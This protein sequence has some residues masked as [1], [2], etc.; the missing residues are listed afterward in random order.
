MDR[1]HAA[2]GRVDVRPALIDQALAVAEPSAGRWFPAAR[3]GLDDKLVLQTARDVV[4][5]GTEALSRT[6]VDQDLITEVGTR[7]HCIVDDTHRRRA[8]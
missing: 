3:E 5:L 1:A 4:E 2:T 7:L 6:G 8:S